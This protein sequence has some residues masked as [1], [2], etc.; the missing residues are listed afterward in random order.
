MLIVADL[1]DLADR[2]S[3]IRPTF[4]WIQQEYRNQAQGSMKDEEDPLNSVIRSMVYLV[5]DGR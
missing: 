4:I 2:S 1:A 5:D 3:L